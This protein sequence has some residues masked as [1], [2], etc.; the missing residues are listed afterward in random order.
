MAFY[1]LLI[2]VVCC[3]FQFVFFSVFLF[4]S[5]GQHHAS[6]LLCSLMVAHYSVHFVALCSLE[7]DHIHYICAFSVR[8]PINTEFWLF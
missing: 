7:D 1:V 5:F 6:I 2:C 8:V 4:S 3:L